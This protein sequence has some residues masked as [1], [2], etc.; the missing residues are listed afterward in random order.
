MMSVEKAYIYEDA[1]CLVT[2]CHNN[3][4]LLVSLIFKYREIKLNKKQLKPDYKCDVIV[5]YMAY[6]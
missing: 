3:G 5:M 6:I 4:T 1:S 2:D